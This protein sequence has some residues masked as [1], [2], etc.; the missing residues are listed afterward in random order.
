M[1]SENKVTLALA[2]QVFR[3]VAGSFS[4]NVGY[5]RIGLQTALMAAST[6]VALPMIVLFVSAQKYFVEG[7]Q[8]TGTKG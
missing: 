8:M 5:Q 2:L 7:I 6:V 1:N 3:T 4:V